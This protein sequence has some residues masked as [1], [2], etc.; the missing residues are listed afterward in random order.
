M[1]EQKQLSNHYKDHEKALSQ[2][3]NDTLTF[4]G[5]DV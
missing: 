1:Y 2:I 5:F 4:V 3:V